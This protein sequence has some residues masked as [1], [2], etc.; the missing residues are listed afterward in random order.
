ME[1]WPWCLFLFGKILIIGDNFE[2]KT[3]GDVTVK[4][5]ILLGAGLTSSLVVCCFFFWWDFDIGNQ[6]GRTPVLRTID[7]LIKIRVI[8]GLPPTDMVSHFSPKQDLGV[9]EVRKDFQYVCMY[10]CMYIY[11]YTW[12]DLCGRT[13][14][15]R[16][17]GHPHRS[18][19]CV[20][21]SPDLK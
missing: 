21:K 15:L 14:E 7:K 5:W 17:A 13:Q 4:T 20:G 16:C 2:K 10:V 1:M 9:Y 6:Y 12:L 3:C 18:K 8:L 11:I 19:A